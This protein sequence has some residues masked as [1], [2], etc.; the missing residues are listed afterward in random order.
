MLKFATEGLNLHDKSA[1]ISDIFKEITQT[2]KVTDIIGVQLIPKQW[3]HHVEILCANEVTK[4]I[5]LNNGLKIQNQDI[6]IYETGLNKVKVAIDNAPLNMDN[7]IIKEALCEFG[8]VLDIRNEYLSVGGKRVPWWNG[9]RHVDMSHLKCELPP[10]LKLHIGEKEIKVRVWHIGQ[11]RI[12]CRWCKEHVVKDE[13]N[14]P[15]RPPRRC[16]NCGSTTHQ[17][18]E[19]VVGKVCFNCNE[20]NHIIR[21]CP[22][23]YQKETGA[24]PETTPKKTNVTNSDDTDNFPPLTSPAVQ[25]ESQTSPAENEQDM[26]LGPPCVDS[27]D[28]RQFD[29]D[30]MKTPTVKCLILGSSNC[31]NLAIPS[32]DDLEI[33]VERRTV[34]G[35]KIKGAYQELDDI[36]AEE[37]QKFRAVVL[38]V[39]ST[40][41]PVETEKDFESC[42]KQYLEN[43]S[44]ISTLCPKAVILMSGILP[45]NDLLDTETNQQ[46]LRFNH[47]LKVLADEEP[48]LIYVD[49]HSRFADGD[50]VIS[51]MYKSS[52]KNKIHLN[53]KGKKRL[54]EM[55]QKTLKEA[56]Y[57]DKLADEWHI[58]SR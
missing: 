21:N 25:Q 11:T 26:D 54:A 34:G 58:G 14:C 2:V 45:R 8:K 43:L 47:K 23:V 36:P 35:L 37:Q 18:E 7:G 10:T 38:H 57:R 40:D 29:P 39:G 44:K 31:R 19:C 46:I 42:Y 56:V 52:D 9:T 33:Q 49:N 20:S 50:Q 41:F 30:S 27:P 1:L 4:D 17:K 24:T 53:S 51:S 28:I 12:E 22:Y 32:D 16:F 48:I 13:H 3:P 5:L 15:K 6:K 55:F